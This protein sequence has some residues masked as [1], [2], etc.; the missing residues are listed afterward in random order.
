MPLTPLSIHLI[1]GTY[2][3]FRQ[4]FGSMRRSSDA[5]REAGPLDATVGVLTSTLQLLEEEDVLVVPGSS[6]NVPWRNHFRVTLLPEA[7]VLRE[8]FARIGRVLARRAEHAR[9]HADAREAA[10]A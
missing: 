3:L 2:E 5:P 4:H 9:G 7:G 1:D 6:F 10:V 8:V